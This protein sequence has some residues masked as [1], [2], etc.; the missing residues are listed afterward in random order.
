MGEFSNDDAIL[1][2]IDEVS[3]R[4]PEDLRA[5]R[6]KTRGL[7]DAKARKELAETYL[8][9]Q[10]R[11][12]PN[13][14]KTG[15][16]PE[17]TEANVSAMADDFRK[18]FEKNTWKKFD[19]SKV[20]VQWLMVAAA[21]L[22]YS[23]ENSNPRS[24]NQQL[25]NILEA[26]KKHNIF[27]PWQYVFADSAVTGTIAARR[28]YQLS[29]RLMKTD[30]G[31]GGLFIDEI[32]RASRDAVEALMLGGMIDSLRKRMIGAT[33]GFDSDKTTS[34]ME[35]HLFAMLH[36]FFVRQ[37]SDKV[38]R[39]MRDAFALGKTVFDVCVGY[40]FVPVLDEAR[41]PVL[42]GD[43]R[44]RRERV[45]DPIEEEQ[46]KQAMIWYADRS[47]SRDAIAKA[48]NEK[49]VGG[50]DKWDAT[51]IKQL[52]KRTVYRGVEFHEMTERIVDK[53]TG[54][55]TIRQKPESEWKRREVSHLRIIPDDLG[56]RVLA[57][58]ARSREIYKKNRT[59]ADPSRTEMQPKSLVRPY[60]SGC[61]KPM[62]LGRSGKYASYFCEYAKTGK[63]GCR[64]R[65]YKAARI[66]DTAVVERVAQELFDDGFVAKVVASA[67]AFLKDGSKLSAEVD[68]ADVRRQI[69]RKQKYLGRLKAAMESKDAA[70][71]QT[72]LDSIS[73]TE[74]AIIELKAKLATAER[75]AAVET[76]PLT[77]ESVKALM[78]N[79][80]DLLRDD[81]G[82]AAPALAKLTG[83][84]L[85]T[86]K[87]GKG[88]KNEWVGHFKLNAVPILVDL[89]RRAGCP[90]AGTLEFLCTGG[91][92]IG[93]KIE[94]WLRTPQ[95]HE[96]IAAEVKL[97]AEG[98]MGVDAIARM[99]KTTWDTAK[100]ALDFASA[101]N[102]RSAKQNVP[103]ASAKRIKKP[104]TDVEAEVVRLRDEEN[105]SF[106]RIAKALGIGSTTASKAY[107][108]GRGEGMPR[109]KRGRFTHL[110][111]EVFATI[112]RML[113]EGRTIP[114]IAIAAGCSVN[115]VQRYKDKKRNEP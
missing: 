100:R 112:E 86:Q 115:T 101:G 17:K 107:E 31:V 40:K 99:L 89:A 91:W 66:I 81:V 27:I 92:T 70:Q 33:D 23:D 45:I 63:G 98:G 16:V 80:S 62:I 71:L 43:G 35:L 2:W 88:G 67:N 3:G 6:A 58:L 85:V 8:E 46:V 44:V 83:P 11:L 42:D 1:E 78:Q 37:L 104:L 7:P 36:E 93:G 55:V 57:R 28:G 90:T 50:Y 68:I 74:G 73:E 110:G 34:R 111:K 51:S 14:V 102:T 79:L 29:K 38:K 52:L 4:D 64:L 30:A 60:C 10:H 56:D 25:K 54:V 49:R 97:L 41:R 103:S 82:A 106:V 21:Y 114:E 84:V 39:G 69:E 15:L 19:A 32:G 18:S 94:V 108:R 76:A 26:A 5:R 22:R 12:Y 20:V 61:R 59:E 75:Q 65:G 109:H 13:L 53:E 48:F 77:T 9:V 47:W 95:K 105:W 24:L 87:S 96:L 113:G 72:A